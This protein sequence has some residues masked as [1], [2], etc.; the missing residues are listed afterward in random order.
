MDKFKE[1]FITCDNQFG[2]KKSSSCSHAIKAAR[3][4]IDN[5]VNNG[6][7]VN[8]CALDVSKAFDKM[9]HHGFFYITYAKTY[10]TKCIENS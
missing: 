1:F 6:S 7:T 4:I 10:S 2:F 3:N 9:N 5:Y 8:L